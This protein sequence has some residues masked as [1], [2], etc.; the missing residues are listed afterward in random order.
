MS[1][2]QVDDAWSCGGML[3]KKTALRGKVGGC[4]SSGS[5]RRLLGQVSEARLGAV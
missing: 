2:C 3:E 1:G 4:S 5:G